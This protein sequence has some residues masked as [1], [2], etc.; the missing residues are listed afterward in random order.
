MLQSSVSR[1]SFLFLWLAT[2]FIYLDGAIPI[3]DRNIGIADI[4]FVVSLLILL[5]S[6]HVGGEFLGATLRHPV[7]GGF[8]LLICLWLSELTLESFRG[9]PNVD[10][11]IWAILQLGF[12]FLIVAPLTFYHARDAWRE[13][14]LWITHAAMIAFCGLTS[15]TDFLHLTSFSSL[16]YYRE[17]N[18]FLGV[19]GFYVFGLVSLF[20]VH[21]ILEALPNW[22]SFLYM[23]L[24]GFGFLGMA[25]AGVRT[26]MGL[27]A[28]SL[29]M[30]LWLYKSEL[31][32]RAGR[33]LGAIVLIATLLVGG[34]FLA[35]NYLPVFR[36]REVVAH[37]DLW[38]DQDRIDMAHAAWSDITNRPSMLGGGLAQFSVVHSEFNGTTVHN[39]YLQ[40]L[41]ESGLAG[42]AV[43]LFTLGAMVGVVF[44]KYRAAARLPGFKPRAHEWCCMF[45]L[46]GWMIAEMVYP[47]GYSR[48]DWVIPLLAI[49]S[50]PPL[51]AWQPGAL[52]VLEAASAVAD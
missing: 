11:S 1:G 7:V 6:P 19:N 15:F 26:G 2:V 41:W 42:G 38:A 27:T 43:W 5:L 31:L 52:M 30:A 28:L 45:A 37:G 47:L 51:R 23:G 24:W 39:L 25:L 14:T 20:L 49:G 33:A 29:G 3:S 22:Q 13:R 21:W 46:L 4:C 32:A 17:Y 16:S 18:V 50:W 12:V 34:V 36:A 10:K 48:S 9:N 35:F 44:R 8:A 40:Q